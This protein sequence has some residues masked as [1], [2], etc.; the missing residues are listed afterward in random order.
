MAS[1]A[2]ATRDGDCW[3]FGGDRMGEVSGRKMM[4]GEGLSGRFI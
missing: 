4:W 2:A 1:G 3:R